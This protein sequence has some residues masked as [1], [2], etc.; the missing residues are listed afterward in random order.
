MNDAKEFDLNLWD[1]K[2]HPERVQAW[3][4]AAYRHDQPSLERLYDTSVQQAVENIRSVNVVHLFASGYPRSGG[5]YR[6]RSVL[7]WLLAHGGRLDALDAYGWLPINYAC[8][9]AYSQTADVLLEAGS[10]VQNDHQPQPLD[11]ALQALAH[12]DVQGAET[13]ARLLLMHGADPNIGS[14][15]DPHFGGVTWLV[16]A[17]VHDRFDWA[18]L[19]WSKGVNTLN[20]KEKQLLIIRGSIDGLVWAQD[21]GMDVSELVSLDHE[22]YHPLQEAKARFESQLLRR[23]VEHNLKL[24][25]NAQEEDGDSKGRRRL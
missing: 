1:L 23:A 20:A 10:P 4:Q 5:L 13:C 16:W 19:L 18:H 7:E 24:K 9:F 6:S 25:E 14:S 15:T 17:L 8:F 11:S 21:H 2:R 22:A 3:F 12:H